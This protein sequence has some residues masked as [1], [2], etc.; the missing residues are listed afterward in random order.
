MNR[1]Y[2]AYPNNPY[3]LGTIEEFTTGNP[4]LSRN[5]LVIP[6]NNLETFY[7]IK[8]GDN[9]TTISFEV[10]QDSKY[11]WILADANDLVIENPFILT[12]GETLRVPNL[13]FALA[14]R[15]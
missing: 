3:A 13:S 9:L 6:K 14:Q 11:W 1:A 15:I 10:Y 4:L 2:K 12:T 8:D 7:T 5:K